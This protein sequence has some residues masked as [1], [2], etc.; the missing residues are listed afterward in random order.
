MPV[1]SQYGRGMPLSVPHHRA[2][3]PF[4]TAT[5]F[6]LILLVVPA[7]ASVSVVGTRW[8]ASLGSAIPNVELAS[9]VGLALLA[10]TTI[11]TAAFAWIRHPERRLRLL[12][13]AA[14]VGLAYAASEGLKLLFAQPRPCTRWSI[15][16]ECPPAGDWSLPSNHATLA[17]GATVVIAI[18][19]G[20]WWVTCSALALAALVAT[21]RVAQ[22]VHYVHDVA[23]GAV[24]G[25]AIT[26]VLIIATVAWQHHSAKTRSS[27]G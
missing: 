4:A 25:L 13:G 7:P 15:A 8:L 19:V 2:L 21:G 24:L 3:L 12:T 9:E 26:T 14:G 18:A 20:R 27:L 17:F 16:T 6:A 1:A 10:A 11:S 5:L 22:G 23:M